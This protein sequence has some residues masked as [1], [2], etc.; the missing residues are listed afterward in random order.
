MATSGPNARP[1]RVAARAALARPGR[2]VPGNPPTGSRVDF[3]R[4]TYYHDFRRGRGEGIRILP[5]DRM[6]I[7][8]SEPAGATTYHD[9][10]LN[11]TRS[12]DYS[13]WTS[14][15]LRLHF[16]GNQLT[17]HWDAHA[18][19]GTFIKTEMRAIM[20]DG[21]SEW[22]TMGIW[23]FDDTEVRRTSVNNQTS[24]YGEVDT[25][26]W[27]A[28]GSHRMHAYQL[29]LTLYRRPR[30]PGS[31]QVWQLGAIASYV[32]VNRTTVPASPPGPAT[33]ITLPVKPYAQNIH[34]GQYP[35]YGGGGEAWCSPT[36][37]EMVVEYWGQRPS[38]H[39]MSWID[40]SYCDPSVDYAA[41]STYDWGYSGTGNWPF[42]TAYASRYGL[43]AMVSRLNSLWELEV[44]IAAG[45]PVI[46]SQAFTKA[47][48]GYTTDGHLFVVIG[49][50]GDGQHVVVN[51]PASDSDVYTLYPRR[52]FEIG[53][54]RVPGPAAPSSGGVV[55]IIKPHWRALPPVVDPRNPSW[56]SAQA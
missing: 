56:P 31:A 10:Y 26:T 19:E 52:E 8:M 4:W 48:M 53:W 16:G 21:H 17:S 37:T 32:P 40:P 5:G 9:P 11:T 42:N 23:S 22:W 12:Y 2:G 24:E 34:S 33:G 49:F 38:K 3:R 44:L 7:V 29:R 36:S 20:E 41:R 28:H 25:D 45:F 30:L 6:G 47:E 18:P 14:E 46:T 35:Q 55:Y 1:P 13:V 54:L 27:N 51:D 15:V 50:T 43:D 39:D